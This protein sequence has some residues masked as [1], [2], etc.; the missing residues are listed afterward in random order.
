MP[1]SGT[2]NAVRS[3]NPQSDA[4]MPWRFW[5][6]YWRVL[7]VVADN[8]NAVKNSSRWIQGDVSVRLE[9][10]LSP[11]SVLTRRSQKFL[12]GSWANNSS[13]WHFPGGGSFFLYLELGRRRMDSSAGLALS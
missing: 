8:C 7:T 9:S 5:C 10:R 12:L 13:R 11:G 6:V 4:G 3:L 1:P 2:A